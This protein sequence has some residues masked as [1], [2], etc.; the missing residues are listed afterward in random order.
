LL[1]EILSKEGKT[2]AALNAVLF[3]DK[4]S[5]QVTFRL[6]ETQKEAA[7]KLIQTYCI[8]KGI[9]VAANPVPIADLM[10]AAVID[11][12]MV[13]HLSKVYGFPLTKAEAGDLVKTIMSQ[14]ILLMGSIWAMNLLSS[15]LKLGSV[16]FSTLITA[17]A[18][19]AVAYYGTYVV[20]QAA[21]YY[22]KH[23]KS[24]GE[25]GPKQAIKRILD[26]ID[27]DS[28]IQHAKEDIMVK[29][30]SS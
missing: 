15:A 25:M 19:G 20:G 22:F 11:A 8:A 17:S 27:R 9:A 21:D 24:W 29:M 28:I 16:G 18:Q 23:G 2:L 5:Q 30:K 12:G 14:I 26:S 10:A 7:E 1:R 6:M 4:L 13:I 3:A